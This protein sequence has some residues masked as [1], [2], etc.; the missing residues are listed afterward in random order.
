MHLNNPSIFK[1]CT[2]SL[3]CTG[4]VCKFTH[5]ALQIQLY[6]DTNSIASRWN[7]SSLMNPFVNAWQ[8]EWND[9]RF[10]H[11]MQFTCVKSYQEFQPFFLYLHSDEVPPVLVMYY[12]R[13]NSTTA[14]ECPVTTGTT[15]L[16]QHVCHKIFSS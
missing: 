15:W 6:K 10:W 9:T 5:V 7:V 2:G 16:V 3:W 4:S 11:V 1:R 13:N 14:I 12:F 8:L